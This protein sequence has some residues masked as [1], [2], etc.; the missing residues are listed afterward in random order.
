ML[1]KNL[2]YCGDDLIAGHS[3]AVMPAAHLARGMSMTCCAIALLGM[4]FELPAMNLPG[5]LQRNYKLC[6]IKS[7]IFASACLASCLLQQF[8]RIKELETC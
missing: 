3:F 2:Q 7:G 5:S 4:I 8:N 1:V 6:F